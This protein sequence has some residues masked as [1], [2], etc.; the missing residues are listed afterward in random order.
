KTTFTQCPSPISEEN[1]TVIDQITFDPDPPVSNQTI[2]IKGHVNTTEDIIDG[3][4]FVFGFTTTNITNPTLLGGNLSFI[5][6]DGKTICPTKNYDID[7]TITAPELPS[8]YVMGAAIV[9]GT[10]N[11]IACGQSLISS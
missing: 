1:T 3:D 9:R 8:E 2:T 11:T 7:F 6:H 10:N 4:V 5:C